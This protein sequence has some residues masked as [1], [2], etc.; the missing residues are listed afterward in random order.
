M[1]KKG[2]ELSLNTIVIIILALL[3]LV[4]LIFVLQ[5]GIIGGT[6][7]YFN[8]SEQAE[9][10]IRSG[11]T[12]AKMFS[13]RMCYKSPCPDTYVQIDGDWA[14]CKKPGSTGTICCEKK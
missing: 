14:D 11:D 5:R 13:G 2:I 12:C 4:A 10:E 8:F 3:V 9:K 6:Q 7:K 1:N